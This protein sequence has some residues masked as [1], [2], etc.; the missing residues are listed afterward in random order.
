MKITYD[1][2]LDALNIILKTGKVSRTVEVA[3]EVFMD[4]DN[5]GIPLYIE[6]IGASEKIGRKNF[7]NINIGGKIVHLSKIAVVR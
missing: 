6:V 5:K 1:S 4:L 3:S 2:K 7:G